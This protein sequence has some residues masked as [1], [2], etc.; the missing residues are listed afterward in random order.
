MSI[1][2]AW[3]EFWQKPPTNEMFSENQSSVAM[4]RQLYAMEYIALRFFTAL[5]ICVAIYSAA[6]WR[7]NPDAGIP[8][9]GLC[10]GMFIGVIAC[11]AIIGGLFGFLFGI[12]RLL[13]RPQAPPQSNNDI[14]TDKSNSASKDSARPAGSDSTSFRTFSGNTNLE[15]IS[16][17]LTKIF[18]GLGLTQATN[19][20][21]GFLS[22]VNVLDSEATRSQ[23]K[24][25]LIGITF[26]SVFIA[27]IIGGFLFLYL[28]T[29]TRV[30]LLLV[31]ADFA[32]VPL[33]QL[34]REVVDAVRNAPFGPEPVNAPTTPAG[35]TP[36]TK[37][38]SDMLSVPYEKLK[39][40]DQLEAWAK[41]QARAGNLQAALKAINDAIAIDPNNAGLLQI[42][43]TVRFMQ[44]NHKGALDALTEARG[45]LGDSA[46][47]A[48]NELFSSLYLPQPEG[49]R[50]A[51]A[52]A[53][54]LFALSKE[55]ESD[56]MV[57]VWLA[58]ARGQQYEYS[59]TDQEKREA[60]KFALIAVKRV[61]ELAPDP[62]SEARTTLRQMFDPALAKSVLTENDLEVF[63]GD[64]EF[65]DLILGL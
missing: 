23:L 26:G 54:R 46:E 50:R 57:H 48:R 13:Q 20:Y 18:V 47:L 29:R 43:A 58:A 11:G 28:E 63:K 24:M 35:T 3:F 44:G 2:Q 17:W 4:I 10:L 7:G 38:D 55:S 49:F 59:K 15:E 31:V 9:L 1:R 6:V 61:I 37:A 51:L 36:V 64:N 45:K 52:A 62:K 56:P 41:A 5:L 12:P 42:L 8:S 34:R 27:S 53:E 32:A 65:A 14:S 30:T 40:V 60:R 25:P 19:I 16:D 39:S 21:A 22:L 33:P